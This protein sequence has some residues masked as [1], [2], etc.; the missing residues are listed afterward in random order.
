[1][2]DVKQA[3]AIA[4]RERAGTT[5]VLLVRAKKDPSK[6]I[7]PKGHIEAGETAAQAA[8]REL[9]EEAGVRGAIA[10]PVGVSSFQSGDERVQVT[11]YLAR[12]V[13]TVPQAEDREYAWLPVDAAKRT[14][15]YDDSKRLLDE[16]VRALKGE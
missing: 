16:A 2:A 1:M 14:L 7:F 3:G 11:Y 15:S 12:F 6:W 13:G 4:V 5:E 8:A 9:A 10:H